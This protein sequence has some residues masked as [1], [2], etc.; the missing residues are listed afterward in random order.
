VLS[1]ETK[2][3][4]AVVTFL[5][6]PLFVAFGE[7]ILFRG[8]MQSRLSA[9]FGKPYRFFEVRIGWGANIA[10]NLFGLIHIGILRWILGLS[11]EVTLA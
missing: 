1:D 5:F 10:S 9:V 8:Y 7:E 4:E 2:K 3:W 6:Y 11:T